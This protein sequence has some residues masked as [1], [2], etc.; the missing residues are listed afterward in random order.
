MAGP[1]TRN[2][3]L[4]PRMIAVRK[5]SR[6]YYYFDRGYAE[7]K[8]YVALGSDFIEAMRKW[9]ELEQG[10]ARIAAARLLTFDDVADRYVREEL[11]QKASRTQ[12]DYLAQL[13]HLRK[14]FG[15]GPLAKIEPIHIRQYLDGR[16]KSPV[17]ANRE[18]ALLS[19]IWNHAREW[20]ATD[21]PNPVSGVRRHGE[22]PRTT[23]IT[24]AQ[25]QALY[26]VA[27]EVLRDAM[28]LAYLTGQRPSDALRMRETDIRDGCLEVR[29]SKT[30]TPLRIEIVGKLATLI[31]RLR[32][33]KSGM[34]IHDT[35]LI[36]GVHGKAVS[37]HYIRTLWVDARN[38]SKLPAELQFRD[39]RAKAVSDKEDATGNIREAQALAGHTTVA[40]T[41]VYSRK[42]RGKK[43]RPVE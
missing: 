37:Q 11:P 3:N 36:V 25:Y 22:K 18:I 28:D 8:R 9:V 16:R 27:P 32:A 17:R 19:A 34:K 43:V 20:G 1:R 33:R 2:V 6:T 7:K 39:L 4:P 15:D 26:A 10:N 12:R 23:Y 31:D 40:M 41:E 14:W 30:G 42:R 38:K 5:R 21:R 13:V 35:A 24:D 29:Q